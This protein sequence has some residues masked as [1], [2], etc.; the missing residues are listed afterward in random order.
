MYKNAPSGYNSNTWEPENS[1]RLPELNGKS[2]DDIAKALESIFKSYKQD[3]TPYGAGTMGP[4]D[5]N[6][7]SLTATLLKKMGYSDEQISDIFDKL[8]GNHWGG[9]RDCQIWRLNKDKS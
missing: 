6:C 4:D 5:F 3:N 7:N 2:G 9:I 8:P 1:V